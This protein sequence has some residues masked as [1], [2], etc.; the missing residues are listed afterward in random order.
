[1]DNELQPTAA[2]ND[3][4]S[5]PISQIPGL[6]SGVSELPEEKVRGRRTGVL[7]DDSD[8]IKLAK[9]GGHKGLLWH[10]ETVASQTNAYKPPEWFC[11]AP[12]E[13]TEPSEEEKSPGVFRQ[14]EAPFGNDN[15]SAWERVDSRNG[16]EKQNN[17]ME[18]LSPNQYQHIGKFKRIMFDKK[19]APVDMSRLL[20]FG[21]AGDDTSTANTDVSS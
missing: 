18:D 11:P 3:G 10:E 15:M 20:S 12:E 1:M 9:Q 2:G 5:A 14:L 13:N 17:Q 16:N 4:V 19:A 21:Y 6:S 7:D 8:Y